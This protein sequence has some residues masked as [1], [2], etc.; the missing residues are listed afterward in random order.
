MWIPVDIFAL[1]RTLNTK[2]PAEVSLAKKSCFQNRQTADDKPSFPLI[3]YITRIQTACQLLETNRKWLPT[4]NLLSLLRILY[5]S[6]HECVWCV[7]PFIFYSR[8]QTS[9][10]TAIWFERSR[11]P[12]LWKELEKKSGKAW[13]YLVIWSYRCLL[14]G[15][16]NFLIKSSWRSRAL[17][18][19]DPNLFSV[20]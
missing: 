15:L 19:S 9:K 5:P 13:V 11:I 10:E 20:M 12:R 3:F 14:V 6:R 18:L 16:S 8:L 7:R 2:K 4:K 17:F 1:A